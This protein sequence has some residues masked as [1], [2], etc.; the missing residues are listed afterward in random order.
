MAPSP[1]DEFIVDSDEHLVATI[2]DL[3]TGPAR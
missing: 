1:A 3:A 2:R